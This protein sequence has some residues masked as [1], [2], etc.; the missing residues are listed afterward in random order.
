MKKYIN[1]LSIT[2]FM[3]SLPI[4]QLVAADDP[5]VEKRKTYSKSYDISGGDRISLNNQF[6]EIKVS[7]W[8][9]N[10]V[11]VDVTIITNAADIGKNNRA[12]LIGNS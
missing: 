8:T 10:E 6:G 5:A 7:T 9:K 11:K 4:Q 3:L 12:K 2:C 1:L